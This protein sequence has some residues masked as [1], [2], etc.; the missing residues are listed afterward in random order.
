MT[1]TQ[2]SKCNK[3]GEFVSDFDAGFSLAEQGMQHAGCGGM[4][5]PH[6]QSSQEYRVY[7]N[8]NSNSN[9]HD[10][11]NDNATNGSDRDQGDG[12]KRM[13]LLPPRPGH[14]AVCAVDH[15]PEEPHDAQS[16]YYQ[17]HF[18]GKV[19][20]WPTWADAIAHCGDQMQKLWKT[21]LA[22]RGAWTEPKSPNEPV[23]L[24]GDP[25]RGKDKKDK[26][27][28]PYQPETDVSLI[29]RFP[30]AIEK[31][32]QEDEFLREGLF[33]PGALREHVFDF[34]D[35]LRVIVSHEEH[36][37][38]RNRERFV[39]FSA[40][41]MPDTK[42][43]ARLKS[44][45]HRDARKK[46]FVEITRECREQFKYVAITG[47]QKLSAC[48]VLDEDFSCGSAEKGV[49]HWFVPIDRFDII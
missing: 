11:D 29:Q 49:P 13:T 19:G 12:S 21:A 36:G 16:L 38:E 9:G 14:C 4:F 35:G 28:L 39:H 30:K 7:S 5:V 33:R 8:S 1:Q 45:A 23:A 26:L 22:Q 2:G 24:P 15:K 42:L 44:L 32:W 25:V 18:F 20:R 17:Y 37:E 6:Q 48:E 43:D 41:I 47:F 10:N 34:E 40:S 46:S 27:V 31:V 3:C